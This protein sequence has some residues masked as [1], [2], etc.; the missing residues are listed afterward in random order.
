M[1]GVLIADNVA[2]GGGGVYASEGSPVYMRGPGMVVE[3]NTA[4]TGGGLLLYA[5]YAQVS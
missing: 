4:A 1:Q 2:A 3:N 5:S